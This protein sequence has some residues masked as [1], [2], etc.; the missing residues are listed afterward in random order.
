MNKILLLSDL[1]FDMHKPRDNAKLF[2]DLEDTKPDIIVLAG[3][4]GELRRESV[5][6]YVKNLCKIAPLIYVLGNHE[7]WYSDKDD[8]ELYIKQ[9]ES[10]P[11]FN[12]LHHGKVVTINGQKFVGDTLWYPQ[13][14]D[15]MNF[16][17]FRTIYGFRKWYGKE[18]D[19]TVK[20]ITE[21]IDKD[22]IVVTHHMPSKMCIHEKY[23][24]DIGW[25]YFFCHD[26]TGLIMDKQPKAWFFGHSHEPVNIKLGNTRLISN[27]RGYRNEEQEVPFNPK[28]IVEI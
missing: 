24:D 17:D 19:A 26:M 13:T 12:H 23:A 28:L 11:N 25:N 21:N 8:V 5:R 4:A 9:L 16:P 22:T 27:P 3:D 20:F 14:E 7:N 6:E 1:H 2:V 15:D 10:T 18:H